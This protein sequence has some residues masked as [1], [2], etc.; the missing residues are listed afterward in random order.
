L[1]PDRAKGAIVNGRTPEEIQKIRLKAAEVEFRAKSDVLFFK[2]LQDDPEQVLRA[3]GFDDPT[4]QE[5]V[6]ELQGDSGRCG[7]FCDGLTCIITSCCF[8]TRDS[9]PETEP[10]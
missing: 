6:S 7:D 8:F 5:F 3:E 4:T 1:G 2:R 10:R 9:L